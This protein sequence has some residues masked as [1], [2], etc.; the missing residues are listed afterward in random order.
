[1]AYR[2]PVFMTPFNSLLVI[3]YLVALSAEE[4]CIITNQLPTGI[5]EDFVRYQ[6][7]IKFVVKREHTCTPEG[8]DVEFGYVQNPTSIKEI[9]K[10]CSDSVICKREKPFQDDKGWVTKTLQSFWKTKKDKLEQKYVKT[11]F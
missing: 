4:N 10:N 3:A 7:V 9:C 11:T 6:K 5:D 2:H 8:I 1:M